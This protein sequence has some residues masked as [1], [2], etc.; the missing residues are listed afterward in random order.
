MQSAGFKL[1]TV[2][3]GV[4]SVKCEAWSVKRGVEFKVWSVKSG[5]QSVVWSLKCGV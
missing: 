3:C 1:Q 5:V 2:K 4:R